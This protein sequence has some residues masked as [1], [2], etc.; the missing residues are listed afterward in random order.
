MFFSCFWAVLSCS[1]FVQKPKKKLSKLFINL[2]TVFKPRFSS[3]GNRH[4]ASWIGTLPRSLFSHGDGA[5]D[6]V[7]P[8]SVGVR[9]PRLL[10][11]QS[12][13]DDGG[14]QCDFSPAI[15]AAITAN[16]RRRRGGGIVLCCVLN[17]TAP[18][19]TRPGRP[20]QAVG[21]RAGYGEDWYPR[22]SYLY[23]V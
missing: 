5:L 22:F 12:S 21:G 8:G 16:R 11:N 6:R 2:K 18:C 9:E 15:M 13:T 19:S 3:P 7:V 10:Y 4:C 23:Q 20:C 14:G 17:T 1:I